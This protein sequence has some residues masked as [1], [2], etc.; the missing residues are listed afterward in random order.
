MESCASGSEGNNQALGLCI[1]S[2]STGLL[3]PLT[4]ILAILAAGVL[5]ALRAA[6]WE[7]R[8]FWH[9]SSAILSRL[10]RKELHLKLVHGLRIGVLILLLC[11][12]ITAQKPKITSPPPQTP[13]QTA[14]T[15]EVKVTET[16]HE[17]TANDLAACLNGFLPM[18]L[19]RENIAGAVVCVVKDGTVL[20]A[21]GYGYSDVDKKT[22][23]SPD[24]TLFRPGSISKLFTWTAI[25]QLVQQ[26][27]IDL[28]REVNE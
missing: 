14:P 1:L 22:R 2:G 5:D 26:G 27:N 10:I 11:A 16:P 24:D 28:D 6:G 9:S 8:R 19:E 18:Q 15:P 23:V 4:S 17:L 3:L 20:F 25:M 21:K 7:L 13:P 12:G